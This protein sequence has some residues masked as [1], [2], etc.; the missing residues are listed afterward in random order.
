MTITTRTP[1]LQTT[2]AD[3][4]GFF[5][6]LASSVAG[7]SVK[8]FDKALDEVAPDP[9]RAIRAQIGELATKHDNHSS[10]REDYAVA[11]AKEG[12][13]A[14][15][16]RHTYSQAGSCM[17]CLLANLS[18]LSAAVDEMTEAGYLDPRET[19]VSHR[20]SFSLDALIPLNVKAEVELREAR[21]EAYWAEA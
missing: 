11:A 21:E 5:G 20:P 15:W 9:E 3:L 10:Q 17:L 19:I 13:A 2:Q 12:R 4:A 14:Y 1:A 18:G 7:P 16:T 8:A 6:R